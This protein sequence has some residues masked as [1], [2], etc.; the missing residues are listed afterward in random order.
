[1]TM[2]FVALGPVWLFLAPLA[3]VAIR[4]AVRELRTELRY[5]A[6]VHRASRRP[7]PPPSKRASARRKARNWV[8]R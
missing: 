2:L 5:R 8:L 4:V 1:M 7:E 6:L 3:L